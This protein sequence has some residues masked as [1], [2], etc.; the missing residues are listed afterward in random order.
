MDQSKFIQLVADVLEVDAETISMTDALEDV[1]WD[2]FSNISFIAEVD[3]A[4]DTS[5]DADI[6]ARATTVADLYD[7]VQSAVGAR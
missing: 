3:S 7:L 4:L 2:S 1:D 6:L 5:I